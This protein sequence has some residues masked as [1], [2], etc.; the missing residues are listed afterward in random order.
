MD[1]LGY[2]VERSSYQE[3]LA[4]MNHPLE[5]STSGKAKNTYDNLD[6]WSTYNN[7]QAVNQAN[8]GHRKLKA[9]GIGVAACLH[10]GCFIPH[11]MV[12]FQRGE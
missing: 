12:D 7:H 6:K 10:H 4:A 1:G 9:T 8:A 5:V 11:T 3:Y 2:M